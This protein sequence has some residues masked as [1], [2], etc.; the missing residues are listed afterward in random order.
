MSQD[1][2]G[3]VWFVIGVGAAIAL[4]VAL[5]PLR[6][7]VPASTLAFVFIALTIVVAEMG[8]RGPG[9]ADGRRLRPQPELLPD[10]AVSLARDPQAR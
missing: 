9:L 10:R 5:T 4:G 8:G 7:L 1:D 6:T 2:R 3:A